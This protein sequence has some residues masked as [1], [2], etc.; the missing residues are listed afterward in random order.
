[1]R[2]ALEM[3]MSREDHQMPKLS[4]DQELSETNK[5]LSETVQ[6]MI[7]KTSDLEKR[8]TDMKR[9]YRLYKQ[10]QSIQCKYC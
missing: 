9:Y 7:Q 3:F 4:K 8:L 6:N 10:A 5:N 1:M 2:E